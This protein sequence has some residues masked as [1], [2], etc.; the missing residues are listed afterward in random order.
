[1]PCQGI[2]IRRGGLGGSASSLTLE[3]ALETRCSGPYLPLHTQHKNDLPQDWQTVFRSQW[4]A[5][6]TAKALSFFQQDNLNETMRN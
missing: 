5:A 4:G 6:N 3:E 1:M 2:P